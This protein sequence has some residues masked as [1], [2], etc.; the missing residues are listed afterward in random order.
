M[1]IHPIGHLIEFI[2]GVQV[3]RYQRAS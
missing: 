2:T 1:G 3:C